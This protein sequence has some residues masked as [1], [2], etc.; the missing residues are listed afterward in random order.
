M[1]EEY[2]TFGGGVVSLILSVCTSYRPI[3]HPSHS[4]KWEKHN[5]THG[6]TRER[7]TESE[8]YVALLDVAKVSPSVPRTMTTD[9]IRQAGAPEPI[10]RL[11]IEIYSHT[12]AVLH[13]HGRDLPIHPKGIKE[14][15]P[16]SPTLFL[17]YHDVL[18]RETFS[19]HPQLPKRTFTCSC[20]TSQ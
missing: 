1:V 6:Q 15:C 16:L 4:P 8:R 19:W 7:P 3:G 5:D 12:P 18:L 10:I 11:L 9:I 2:T 20:T 17:L 13:I 14:G